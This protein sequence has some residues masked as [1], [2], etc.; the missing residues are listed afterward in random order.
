MADRRFTDLELERSL[1]GDLQLREPTAADNTRLNE[2]R[3]EHAAF[4]GSI[5][6]AAEVKAIE[7]RVAKA[8]PVAKPRFAWWKWAAPAGALA[9]AAAAVLVL[10]GKKPAPKEDD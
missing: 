1:A 8:A 3:A 4:L 9:A 6:V 10:V 5:D 2:L 7:K